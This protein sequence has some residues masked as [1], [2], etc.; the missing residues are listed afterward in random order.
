MSSDHTASL[1]SRRRFLK[2]AILSGMGCASLFGG[3]YPATAS[4]LNSLEEGGRTLSFQNVHT[5][6]VFSGEYKVG[7]RY[8]P[9][10]FSEI[11][12]VLRDFRTGDEYPMDPRVVDIMY[13]IHKKTGRATPF[14]ILSGYRSP[15]TNQMLRKTST[16][17]AK[18]SFHMTGQAIDLRMPS[19]S[20]R[21]IRNIALA[22]RA[23]GVGFYAGSDFVHIDTG[24][25][26][27]W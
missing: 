22:L 13:T 24:Q 18:N 27:S 11:N 6:E 26:R 23:G 1:F 17:V 4:V 8:L 9:D 7:G 25:V 19:F 21:E 2:T 3:A 20:T 15:K 5:G 10:A 12:R 14:E 16:G